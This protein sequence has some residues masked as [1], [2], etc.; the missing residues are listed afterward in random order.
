MQSLHEFAKLWLSDMRLFSRLV[1]RRPLRRYQLEIAQ[2]IITSVLHRQGLTFAVMLPR[3][4]GKNETQAQ[5]EAYLLNLYQRVG[6]QIVK[7]SPTFKPQTQNSIRR[8]QQALDNDWNRQAAATESGYIVK[9]GRARAL[10]F[11]AEPTANVVGA[12]ANLLLECDEAQDVAVEKWQK[13]FV[14]MAASTNATRVLWGTAWTSD[15]LLART[16][17]ELRRQEAQDGIK[18][19]FTITPDQVAD[20]Q[21]A[22][23]KFLADQ[24]ARLGRQHPLV[25]TQYYLEEIDGSGGLFPPERQALMLGA[26]AREADGPSPLWAGALYCFC[27]DVAGGDE[28]ATG[29]QALVERASPSARRDS[30]ALTVFRIDLSSL[31]DLRAPIYRVVRRYVWTDVPLA[32]LY[33]QIKNLAE[34]WRARHVVIDATGIGAG[35]A[36]FLLRALPR[37]DA[38]LPF[39][40]TQ[41]SK[42]KLA[43]D[44]LTILDAGRFLDHADDDP[45]SQGIPMPGTEDDLRR[46]FRRQLAACEYEI[47]SGPGQVIRWGVPDGKK[48]SEGEIHDDLLTSAM[49]CAQLDGLAWSIAQPA[50]LIPG[51]DPLDQMDKKDY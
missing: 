46:L 32:N 47:L 2:A 42:S 48:D 16:I 29:W 49:L 9:L 43:W 5:I 11:S 15:T 22:Y 45:R 6:G 8:L 4:S 12:T 51:R 41:A 38:V 21:P 33:G 35:L 13:D 40:F 1:I 10:F 37:V 24:V 30:T 25:K 18:R 19:V 20:E 26:H 14:P 3:Q 39:V 31:A 50:T 27:I 36:S 28:G 23:G 7:A 34:L 17:A 44:F